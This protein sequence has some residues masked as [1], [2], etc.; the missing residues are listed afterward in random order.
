MHPTPTAKVFTPPVS[1]SDTSSLAGPAV[2][3]GPLTD[4]ADLGAAR[5]DIGLDICGVKHVAGDPPE[6]RAAL[7]SETEASALALTFSVLGDPSRI[8]LLD[9]LSAHE[10]C[11]C[12]LASLVHLSESAVSHQLR[13]LRTLRLVRTRRSGRQVFY[14]LD[15]DHIRTL[16]EQGRRHIEEA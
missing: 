4:R 5:T 10:L 14:A 11:V 2:P 6:Q 15:D 12:D 16:L 8:R 7:M 9:A 1:T 3:A 13:L